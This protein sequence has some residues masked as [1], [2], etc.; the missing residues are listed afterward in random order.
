MS[1]PVSGDD[2]RLALEHFFRC[3]SDLILSWVCA[4]AG[5]LQV[6]HVLTGFLSQEVEG[7]ALPLSCFDQV[8]LSE[9]GKLTINFWGD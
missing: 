4:T 2:E 7:V 6:N 8:V 3:I 5:I 9:G 1:S